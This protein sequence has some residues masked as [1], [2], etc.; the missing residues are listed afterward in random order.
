VHNEVIALFSL[1]HLAAIAVLSARDNDPSMR[2]IG[3]RAARLIGYVD[4]RLN[5][6]EALREYSEQQEYDATVAALSRS[7]GEEHESL[8]AQGRAWS[9]EKA[10]AE[11]SLL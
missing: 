3:G 6:L 5:D 1:Q 10:V 7:L 9:Q 2:D 4:A 11:A 8:A